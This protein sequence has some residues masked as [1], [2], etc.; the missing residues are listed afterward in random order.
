MSANQDLVLDRAVRDWVLVPLT[1]TI[2][3]IMVLRQYATQMGQGPGKLKTKTDPKEIREKQAIARSQLLRTNCGFVP[4]AAFRQRAAYF[5]TKDTGV[6]RQASVAKSA[7]EQML[8]N[9]EMMTDM[10]KKNLG[11]IV[12][13]MG[14]G[15]FVN[16]FFSGFI[17]G[18]IPFP[19]SPSF[20]LMLQRGLDLPSLD[21]TYFTSLSYY[22]L[23]LFGLR[24]VFT[25][26]FREETIDET[27]MYRQQMGMAGAGMPGMDNKKMFEGECS[28]LEMMEYKWRLED[29]PAQAV[30]TLKQCL[31]QHQ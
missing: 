16:Y 20:R 6:F 23:L 31:Q 3:L 19:L 7:Q 28:A 25:L 12:P 1:L 30:L 5:S 14:M 26:W 18:K 15:M 4:E 8:T 27:Q 17:L 9:P 11:G 22:I 2:A 24:G 21:V 29:A 13:Q 10:L